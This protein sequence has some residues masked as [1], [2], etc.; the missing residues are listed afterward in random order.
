MIARLTR[1]P[2][3]VVL[4]VLTLALV[5]LLLRIDAS[6]DRGAQ[7][8][9]LD[10]GEPSR[11][12]APD[13]HH[14]TDSRDTSRRPAEEE[15]HAQTEGHQEL[16]TRVDELQT[17][18]DADDWS[19][20]YGGEELWEKHYAL[21]S[22]GQ[23]L[24]ERMRL[25]EVLLTMTEDFY[26][27]AWQAGNFQSELVTPDEKGAIT[28]PRRI[29]GDGD[30]TSTRVNAVTGGVQWVTLPRDEFPDAYQVAKQINWLSSREEYLKS[31]PFQ[32]NK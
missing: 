5:L 17:R 29:Y 30:L 31:L 25:Q 3:L 1:R 9:V 2:T 28:V 19:I 23:V 6:F 27:G 14:S 15:Q 18:V 8:P 20:T 7:A 32:R 12:S 21:A 13:S 24:D 22:L 10:H 26:E 16:Q 4:L 11:R